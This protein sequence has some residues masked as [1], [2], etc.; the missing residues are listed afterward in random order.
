MALFDLLPSPFVGI[1][2]GE[3]LM[4]ALLLLLEFLPILLL[5]GVKLVLLLLVFPVLLGVPRIWRRTALERRKFAGMD[6]VGATRVVVLRRIHRSRIGLSPIAST[7]VALSCVSRAAMNRT[8]L[9]GVLDTMLV[10]CSGP[11]SGGDGRLA[12]IYGSA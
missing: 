5:L 6:C 12:T 9:A 7:R 8:A 3:L 1:F 2:P 11:G 4:F 10:K